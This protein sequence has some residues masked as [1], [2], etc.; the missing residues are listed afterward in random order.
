VHAYIYECQIRDRPYR[1]DPR[2]GTFSLSL[3][4]SN[5]L[6]RSLVVVTAGMR[7]HAAMSSVP[8]ARTM[9]YKTRKRNVTVTLSE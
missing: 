2:R 4:L 5:C 8:L 1:L 7:R 3:S 6:A 9:R